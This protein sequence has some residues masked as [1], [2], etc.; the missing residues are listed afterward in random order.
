MQVQ[1]LVAPDLT[2]SKCWVGEKQADVVEEP[3]ELVPAVIATLLLPPL[4]TLLLPPMPGIG[5]QGPSSTAIHAV[6]L[7]IS[8]TPC[9]HTLASLAGLQ[10]Q[11]VA[12]VWYAEDR[13]CV[14]EKQVEPL[15]PPVA[16]PPTLTFRLPPTV[17][18]G[19]SVVPPQPKPNE[20][21]QVNAWT[22]L[23]QWAPRGRAEKCIVAERDCK[24]YADARAANYGKIPAICPTG[25]C[26]YSRGTG[27]L[28]GFSRGGFSYLHQSRLSL[29]H[30]SSRAWSVIVDVNSR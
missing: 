11:P 30:G 4:T 22:N 14:G 29:I 12:P 15:A 28:V 21:A 5:M 25:L 23:S 7:Q 6:L 24:M 27:R 17:L 19:L 13:F 1:P 2:S 26:Q 10:A 18:P 8:A 20:L 16:L 3:A 9:T